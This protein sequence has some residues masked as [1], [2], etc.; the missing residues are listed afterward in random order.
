MAEMMV[1]MLPGMEM[2]RMVN[3]GTEAVM[4]ALR[5][6]RGVTGRDKI[7]KFA[8]CYHGHSDSLL[9][10]AGSGVLTDSLPDSMGVSKAAAADTLTAEYNQLSS[11]ESLF[12]Q[13]GAEIA[14]IVVEP[15]AANMGVIP[16]QEGFLQGL[17]AICDRYGALL[18]FDEV[19]TGFRLAP[20]GAQEY[21]G[22]QADI[23][24]FGKIIGGGMPVGAYAARRDFMKQVAPSGGIYQAGTLSGNPVAMAAGL[25]QLSMIQDRGDRLYQMLTGYAEKMAEGLEQSARENGISVTVN[26]EGSLFSVF[27]HDGPVQNERQAKESDTQRFKHYFHGMLSRGIYLAPS[28]FEAVFVSA[29]HTQKDL[30]KTLAAADEVMRELAGL[31]ALQQK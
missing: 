27:F 14:A 16:P 19:I 10:R 29:A 22:I 1:S 26:R 5:L 24:A 9:V 4:S 20:G 21:Y 15:V 25:A 17:R 13:H 28:Q 31:Q 2:V 12:E 7:V 6:A 18:V 3:S 8:G 30:E 11:V 23:A